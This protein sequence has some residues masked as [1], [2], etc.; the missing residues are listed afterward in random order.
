M[1]KIREIAGLPM[2]C[3]GFSPLLREPPTAMQTLHIYAYMPNVVTGCKPAFKLVSC[4]HPMVELCP[5]APLS[6]LSVS[7]SNRIL[8]I[9]LYLLQWDLKLSTHT[10]Q[11]I[12]KVLQST[13]TKH[14][15]SVWTDGSS[16]IFKTPNTLLTYPSFGTT[17]QLSVLDDPTQ[18][19]V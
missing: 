13:R 15:N 11:S 5:H 7:K 8:H 10:L 14:F 9:Y 1:S 3:W 6:H 19:S 4:M 18:S 2:G 16:D 17:P 12:S